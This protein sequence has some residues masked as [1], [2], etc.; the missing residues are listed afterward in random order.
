MVC[1]GGSSREPPKRPYVEES[2]CGRVKGTAGE[3]EC[4]PGDWADVH[5]LGSKKDQWGS[6]VE[7]SGVREGKGDKEAFWVGEPWE[8]LSREAYWGVLRCS[9]PSAPFPPRHLEGG[10]GKR[11]YGIWESFIGTWI[12][13]TCQHLGQRS[14]YPAAYTAIVSCLCLLQSFV[15][16][17]LQRDRILGVLPID[18]LNLLF[19]FHQLACDLQEQLFNAYGTQEGQKKG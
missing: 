11:R 18:P 17:L 15:L 14:L 12:G 19:L 8:D 5:G 3:A 6:G 9:P 13:S 10:H 16:Q 7:W 1:N 2:S 4:D